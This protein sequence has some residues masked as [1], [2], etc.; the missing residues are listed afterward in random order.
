VLR[1]REALHEL[2]ERKA[3]LLN[4]REGELHLRLHTGDPD[5]SK[6]AL[7][8]RRVVEH[9]GL[10]D[11]RFAMHDQYAAASVAGTVQQSVDHV[12]FT[13]PAKQPP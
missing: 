5:N 7:R 13:I 1:L 4:P 9:G 10:P 2:E 12:A 11:S 3:Q 8:L 6:L